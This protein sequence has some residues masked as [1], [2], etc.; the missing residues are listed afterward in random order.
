VEPLKRAGC[1]GGDR[2]VSERDNSC[3]HAVHRMARRSVD[4]EEAQCK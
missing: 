2:K 1:N 4:T 3:S